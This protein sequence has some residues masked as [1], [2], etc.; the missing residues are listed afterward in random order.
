MQQTKKLVLSALFAALVCIATMMIRI[1]IPATSGYVHLG[2]AFVILCGVFLN[3]AA[4]FL[5][6]GIGSCLADLLGGYFI[7]VPITFLIKGLVALVGS[8]VYHSITKKSETKAST[9]TAFILCG[10][11]D[12][13]FVVGGY[14][15]CETV[16]Y[17]F[18]PALVSMIPNAIQ[19]VSG[20]VISFIFY[21]L[22]SAIPDVKRLM[23]EH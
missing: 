11:F 13:L 17:G 9:S 4:A 12:I 21:Q 10:I 20:L 23:I 14:A 2:D 3:P 8:Y 18:Q 1:P 6:A 19:G 5:A 22:F 16:L 15:I 7:Y